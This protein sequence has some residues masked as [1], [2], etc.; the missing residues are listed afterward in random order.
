MTDIDRRRGKWVARWREPSGRQRSRAFIRYQ[1]AQR[2]LTSVQAELD[3]GSYIPHEHGAVTLRD[4]GETWLA[5]QVTEP[6]TRIMV[7]MRWRKHICP[8]LGDVPLAA[9]ARQPSLIRTWIAGLEREGMAA[10]YIRVT[11]GTLSAVLNSAVDDHMIS[12]NPCSARSVRAPKVPTG[13]VQPWEPETVAAVRA[14]LSER[15][16]ALADCA[17]G[18]G[19][20]QGECFALSPDDINWPRGSVVHV[21]RQVRLVGYRAVFSAP[22]NHETRTVPLSE[23]VKLRLAAHMAA[24]PAVPV[25]LPER[26]PGGKLVTVKLMFTTPTRRQINRNTFN[27]YEWKPALEAAG[28]P[29]TR[30]NGMHVLRHTYASVLLAD[31]VS[32]GDVSEWLGHNDPGFTLRVYRHMMKSAPDR[33]RAAIDAMFADERILQDH[34]RPAVRP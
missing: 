1:D 2:H 26:E 24:F 3:R 9:L 19:M 18:C 5:A 30:G 27:T 33:A 7:E 4:Y 12:T 14:A 8:V 20:R 10:S 11:L 17:G 32:I 16:R 34:V 23:S 6:T 25:T 21:R 28:V 15:Y 29:Q 13:K 22:K 31:G